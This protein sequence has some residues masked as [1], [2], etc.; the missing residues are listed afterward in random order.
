[1]P[2]VWAHAEHIKLPRSLRGERVF[3][4]PPQPRRPYQIDRVQFRF[5]CWRSN[6][7][8]TSLR[9][10]KFLRIELPKAALVHWSIDNCSTSA[11]ARG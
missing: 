5:S 8:A 6:H 4:M 9:A 11:D 10:G 7:K 1:M 3:D 2:L